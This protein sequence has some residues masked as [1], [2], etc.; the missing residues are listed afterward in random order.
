MK[1]L[2]RRKNSKKWESVDSVGYSYE[3]ELQSLLEESPNLIPTEELLGEKSSSFVIGVSEFGLP[4]SGSTDIVAFNPAGQIAVIECKLAN[5][6]EIKRKVVGQI[7]EYAAY[8]WKMSYIEI[9]EKVLKSKG[10]HLVDLMRE[11]VDDPDWNEEDFRRNVND[12]LQKGS[13]H[14]VISVDQIN[15]E[16]RRTI[17]FLS[18]CGNS[19]FTFTALELCYF[20][21]SESLD[22]EILIPHLFGAEIEQKP[23]TGLSKGPITMDE[24]IKKFRE[25]APDSADAAEKLL[26]EIG[27][28]PQ[29][30]IILHRASLSVEF[31]HPRDNRKRFI[32]FYVTI[33]GYVYV[34]FLRDQL[35]SAGLPIDIGINFVKES[36]Q[37]FENIEVYADN[38]Q[39]WTDSVSVKEFREKYIEFMTLVRKTIDLIKQEFKK[40]KS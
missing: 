13:F 23:P 24:F 16:L 39:I 32:F 10:K 28:D 3:S 15:E 40:P 17:E 34:D 9:D 18:N 30:R 20:G 29:L 31:P 8:L 4:G 2:I 33:D 37:L 22:H 38:T 35:K 1:I 27:K 5:N 12:S 25:N 36:A 21:K 11:Y 14:L 7:F 6:P 26:H 19:E